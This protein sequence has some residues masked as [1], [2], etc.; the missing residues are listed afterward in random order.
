[1]SK[2]VRNSDG[3]FTMIKLCKRSNRKKKKGVN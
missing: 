3:T 2:V 1:M